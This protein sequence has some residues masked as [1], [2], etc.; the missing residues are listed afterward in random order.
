MPESI[1]TYETC[2]ACYV[3]V[4]DLDCEGHESEQEAIKSAEE[5]LQRPGQGCVAVVKV[6]T[7]V[8][9]KEGLE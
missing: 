8:R 2:K 4:I 5:D 9:R 6:L 3:T 1:F 7:V